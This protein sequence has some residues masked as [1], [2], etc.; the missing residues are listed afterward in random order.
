ML[1]CVHAGIDGAAAALNQAGGA[2][3]HDEAHNPGEE[4]HMMGQA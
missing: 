4:P 3:P 1:H 2:V